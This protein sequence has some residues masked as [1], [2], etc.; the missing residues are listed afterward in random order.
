MSARRFQTREMAEKKIRGLGEL[1]IYH[2]DRKGVGPAWGSCDGIISIFQP[3]IRN[4][5]KGEFS[6]SRLIARVLT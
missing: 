4:S 5:V 3:K 2:A 1:P 6:T